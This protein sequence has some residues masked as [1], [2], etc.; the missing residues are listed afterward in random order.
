MAGRLDLTVKH[1][2]SGIAE[3]WAV[4]CIPISYDNSAPLRHRQRRYLSQD[5]NVTENL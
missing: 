3:E 2:G 4:F 1:R 5:T